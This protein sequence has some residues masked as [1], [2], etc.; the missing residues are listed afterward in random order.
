MKTVLGTREAL[1]KVSGL[2]AL[3]FVASCANS[4]L[5]PESAPQAPPLPSY[6][7]ISEERVVG[8]HTSINSVQSLGATDLR[9]L[10]DYALANNPEINAAIQL[11]RAALERVPQVT[12][13]P[14]PK[15]SYRYFFEEVE[16]RVGPQE[17][18][19]GLSQTLP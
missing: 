2:F 11:H 19:I 16:T 18:T 4:G 10:V 1:K 8:H 17:H 13:L 6:Q 5:T 3:S 7:G 12:A 15:L 14:D 9:Q